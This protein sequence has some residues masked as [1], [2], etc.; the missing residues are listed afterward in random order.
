MNGKNLK[1]WI[2]ILLKNSP[3]FISCSYLGTVAYLIFIFIYEIMY[4][5]KKQKYSNSTETFDAMW[6]IRSRYIC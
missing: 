4:T 1:R 5:N 6:S 2:G 3:C